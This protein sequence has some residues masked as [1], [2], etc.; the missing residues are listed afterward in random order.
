MKQVITGL[1]LLVVMLMS[2][3]K[4]AQVVRVRFE[5]QTMWNFT[6]IYVN[7]HKLGDL[8]IGETTGYTE[9]SEYNLHDNKPEPESFSGNISP[10]ERL[11][12]VQPTS[13]NPALLGRIE[14]MSPGDYTVVLKSGYYTQSTNTYITFNF[15]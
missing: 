5:N 10:T 14:K 6:N 2:C 11:A 9:Y 1:L 3:K 8:S 4:S 12:F 15:K 13:S 7:E